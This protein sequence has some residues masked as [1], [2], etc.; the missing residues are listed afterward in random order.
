M[1]IRD[2]KEGAEADAS[3]LRKEIIEDSDMYCANA[4]KLEEAEA[5]LEKLKASGRGR[6]GAAPEPEKEEED[7]PV[8]QVYKIFAERH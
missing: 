3:R 8:I 5:E 1:C 4:K 2:R 6:R 7:S